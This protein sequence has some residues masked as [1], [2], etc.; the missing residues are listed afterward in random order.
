MHSPNT[1]FLPTEVELS[2]VVF[3][4]GTCARALPS[5]AQDGLRPRNTRQAQSHWKKHPSHPGA[6]YITSAYALHYAGNAVTGGLAAML[7]VDYAQLEPELLV[8]DEDSYA[9]ARVQGQEHLERLP[10][11]ARVNYWR[12]HLAGTSASESLRVLGNC[13]YLGTI[14]PKAI[15]AVR[16]LSTAEM[17]R[18]VVGVS[19]PAINPMN[20][21]IVGGMNQRLTAWLLGQDRLAD[22]ELSAWFTQV[23]KPALPLMTLP[24]AAEHV[25]ALGT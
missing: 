12:D 21:K 4:H 22:A 20:F 8:A 5:I 9:L 15:R 10:L 14:P 2:K 1:L 23:C 25:L 6:V 7:D 11:T 17:V 13:A 3:C 18:L 19:D 24:E 16:L